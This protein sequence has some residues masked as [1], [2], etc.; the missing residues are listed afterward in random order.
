MAWW[1][2]RLCDFVAAL[3]LLIVLSPLMAVLAG[4]IYLAG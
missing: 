2:K 1:T 4:L 3:L